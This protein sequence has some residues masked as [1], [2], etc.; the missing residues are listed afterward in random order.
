[1][2]NAVLIKPA[3]F[4]HVVGRT[5]EEA[6]RILDFMNRDTGDENKTMIRFPTAMYFH[7]ENWVVVNTPGIKQQ[8]MKVDDFCNEIMAHILGER[9]VYSEACVVIEQGEWIRSNVTY[10]KKEHPQHEVN[11]SFLD[12]VPVNAA[13]QSIAPDYDKPED[14]VNLKEWWTNNGGSRKKMQEHCEFGT[15]REF[16]CSIDNEPEVEDSPP[17]HADP[18]VVVIDN[19]VAEDVTLESVKRKLDAAVHELE[20]LIRKTSRH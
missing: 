2:D 11:R 10:P 1:M 6:L 9:L 8:T 7:K 14:L 16:L 4:V 12:E 19:P 3:Q 13:W 5:K 15:N 18:I 17:R 20:A